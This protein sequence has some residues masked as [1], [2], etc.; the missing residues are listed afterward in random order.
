MQ[1]KQ[2]VS[3]LHRDGWRMGSKDFTNL[4]I[5]LKI[6]SPGEA[7]GAVQILVKYRG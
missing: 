4:L 2:F 1:H 3:F 5:T 6:L 7:Y